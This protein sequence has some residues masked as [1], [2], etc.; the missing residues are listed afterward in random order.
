M[1]ARI[2]ESVSEAT[3]RILKAPFS[4][5]VGQASDYRQLETSVMVS[6]FVI[7]THIIG[8]E[9]AEIFYKLYIFKMLNY[10]A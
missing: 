7:F 9:M 3:A 8:A 4:V 2:R 1:S 10:I 5:C 6:Y